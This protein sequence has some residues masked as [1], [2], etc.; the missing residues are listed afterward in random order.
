MKVTLGLAL[1]QILR[2]TSDFINIF[3]WHYVRFA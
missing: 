3:M 2:V 1:F